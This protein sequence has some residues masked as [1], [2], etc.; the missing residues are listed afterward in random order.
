LCPLKTFPKNL[1]AY[2]VPTGAGF[3]R[4]VIGASRESLDTFL[5]CVYIAAQMKRHCKARPRRENQPQDAT[6]H[7]RCHRDELDAWKQAAQDRSLTLADYVRA[8]MSR[9]PNKQTTAQRSNGGTK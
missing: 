8:Q 7:M 1:C 3:V 6:M 9:K 5:Q 2:V 4:G